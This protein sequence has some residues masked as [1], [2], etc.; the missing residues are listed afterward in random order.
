MS[1]TLGKNLA[2]FALQALE[3]LAQPYTTDLVVSYR[4]AE[5]YAEVMNA[6]YHALYLLD[7]F[8]RQLYFFDETRPIEGT[9]I[10]WVRSRITWFQVGPIASITAPGELHPELWVGGYDGSWSFGNT[11]LNETVNAPDLLK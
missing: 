5:L 4:T 8:D 9:N 6:G 2:R 10:P 3:D 11:V 1:D 7:V